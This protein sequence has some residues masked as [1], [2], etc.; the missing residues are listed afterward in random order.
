[1]AWKPTFPVM[2]SSPSTHLGLPGTIPGVLPNLPLLASG[3]HSYPSSCPKLILFVSDDKTKPEPGTHP[4]LPL[5]QRSVLG[6]P[7]SP[8]PASLGQHDDGSSTAL[9]GSL[10]STDGGDFGGIT[11][12]GGCPAQLLKQLPV[13][14]GGLCL[15]GNL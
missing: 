6:S 9:E 15:P 11:A 1:M 5:T 14:H 10:Y 13:V 12:Q 8:S 2:P 3:S 4:S 7:V